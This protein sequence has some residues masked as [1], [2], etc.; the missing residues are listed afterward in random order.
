MLA[1]IVVGIEQPIHVVDGVALCHG[2]PRTA[3]RKAGGVLSRT[4]GYLGVKPV[5]SWG[6]AL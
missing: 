4:L 6:D 3:G 1:G 5:V 2:E